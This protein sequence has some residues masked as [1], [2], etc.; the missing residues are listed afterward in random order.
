MRV[1][2]SSLHVVFA[3]PSSSHSAPAPAWGPTNFSN[4]SPSHGLQFCTNCSRVDLFHGV[5]SSSVGPPWE[6]S[7][8]ALV[9]APVSMGP[10]V[11]PG[12]C[13]SMGSP[14]GRSLLRAS[15]CSNVGSPWAAARDLLH[16]G[17][18]WAAGNSLPHQGLLHGLQGNLCSSTWSTSFPASALTLAS[19][20]LFLS[21]HLIPL[22]SCK[23]PSSKFSSPFLTMLSQ[24]RY[25]CHYGLGLGQQRVCLGAGWH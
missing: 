13:S 14:Q 2:I 8:L 5:Q 15:P 12:A 17:P 1:A 10:Q 20:E 19:A 22:S 4:V 11:L 21:H 7:K 3:A 9:W 6:T 24:R 25:H 16:R 18:P 23:M